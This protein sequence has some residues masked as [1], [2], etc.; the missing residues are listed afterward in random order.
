MTTRAQNSLSKFFKKLK[1]V[2]QDTQTPTEMRALGNEAIDIIVKRSR[3]GYGAQEGSSPGQRFRFARLSE[4]YINFRKKSGVLSEFTSAG[5]SN[6]TFTGQLLDSMKI[7]RIS[8]GVVTISPTGSRKDKYSRPGKTNLSV[9]E[10]LAEQ[11][12]TFN[13]LTIPEYKQLIRF[14]RTR[15]GDLKRRRSLT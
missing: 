11:G 13:R 1:D 8:K 2:V 3:L 9:A 4:D 6:I 10:H 14:Y 7:V 12:R 15:F 5:K